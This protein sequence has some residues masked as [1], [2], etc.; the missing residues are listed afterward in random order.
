MK[1][2]QLVFLLL[3][4]EYLINYVYVL[5]DHYNNI[6]EVSVTARCKAAHIKTEHSTIFTFI[7]LHILNSGAET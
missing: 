7:F 3:A 2:F 1:F 6:E 4:G 5:K